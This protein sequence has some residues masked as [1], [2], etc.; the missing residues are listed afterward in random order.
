MGRQVARIA[1]ALLAAALS[2]ACGGAS[3]PT[4][5][6]AAAASLTALGIAGAPDIM[7]VGETAT[8]S[9]QGTWSDGGSRP[10]TLQWST[11]APAVLSVDAGSVVARAP[12]I[13]TVSVSS[14]STSTSVRVRV[15]PNLGG[16]WSG[17][18]RY[19]TCSVPARWG[20]GFCPQTG[21]SYSATLE[22][23]QQRDTV[24]G[25]LDAGRSGTV[26]GTIQNDGALQ[27]TGQLTSVA[28]TR[29]LRFDIRDWSTSLASDGSMR[30]RWA[31]VI[32]WAGESGQGLL[33]VEV[34]R[35]AKR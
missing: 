2:G 4:S 12:G 7:L 31:E 15:V 5:P 26:R 34:I 6:S 11:D 14:G 9:V 17:S 30:G 18:V 21:S 10:L 24:V 3:S 13:A 1:L 8:L 19:P 22:L 28:T 25:T 32:T 20:S 16:T 35:L 23:V 29:T 33:D 27:L